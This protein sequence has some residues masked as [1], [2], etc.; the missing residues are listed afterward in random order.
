[1]LIIILITRIN[2]DLLH[3]SDSL[4]DSCL[5]HVPLHDRLS[6]EVGSRGLGVYD[7]GLSFLLTQFE[8]WQIQRNCF[9]SRHLLAENF[10]SQGVFDSLLYQAPHWAGSELRVVTGID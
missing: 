10:D 8:V 7:E 9:S 5:L 6:C 2:M 4:L 1:M 3:Y